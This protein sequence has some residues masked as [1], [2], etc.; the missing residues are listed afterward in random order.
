[1]KAKL[2]ESGY[3]GT[4]AAVIWKSIEDLQIRVARLERES[5]KKKA[6]KR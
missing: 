5:K 4:A 2:S 3:T 1:M 6:R